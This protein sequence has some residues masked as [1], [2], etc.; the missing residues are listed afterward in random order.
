MFDDASSASNS[1]PAI[2]KLI[3]DAA[4]IPG[5]R[6]VHYLG[7]FSDR[8]SFSVQQTRALNLIWALHRKG[9]LRSDDPVAVVGGGLAG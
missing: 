9:H 4:E 2:A 7:P 8:I 6:N 3:L 1:V 5:R